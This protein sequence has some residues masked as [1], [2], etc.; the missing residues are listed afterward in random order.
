[1]CLFLTNAYIGL[2]RK[3]EL[4]VCKNDLKGSI[5]YG[6][7]LYESSTGISA[8]REGYVLSPFFSTIECY[9]KRNYFNYYTYMHTFCL[10]VFRKFVFWCVPHA[11]VATLD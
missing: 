1:M 3:K 4:H 7:E 2:F 6:Q 5:C 11:L 8:R 9:L 10:P